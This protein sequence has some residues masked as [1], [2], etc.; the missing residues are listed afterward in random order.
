M[1]DLIK[2]ISSNDVVKVSRIFAESMKEKINNV[3]VEEKIK[4][5]QSIMVE[6]ESTKDDDDD[7]DD[8]DDDSDDDDDSDEGKEK[9]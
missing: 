7:S 1:D 6:G 2:A 4:I 5:A 3:L 9:K 8:H